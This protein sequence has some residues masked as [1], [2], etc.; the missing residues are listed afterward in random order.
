MKKSS[1]NNITED[2][3]GNKVCA[4][5]LAPI[6]ELTGVAVANF[7]DWTFKLITKYQPCPCLEQEEES[8]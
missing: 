5:C 6:E 1:M 8:A 4:F 3:N 2:R 7:D